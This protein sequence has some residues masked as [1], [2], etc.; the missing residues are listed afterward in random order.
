MNVSD[1][2]LLMDMYS[3]VCFS[4]MASR[5]LG[6]FIFLFL[7]TN[8]ASKSSTSEGNIPNTIFKTIAI[9]ATA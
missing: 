4:P 5:L 2:Y 1:L 7:L 6:R 3:L 8:Y 9:T